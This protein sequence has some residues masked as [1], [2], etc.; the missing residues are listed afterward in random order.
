MSSSVERITAQSK[1]EAVHGRAAALVQRQRQ[2]NDR[3]D[4]FFREIAEVRT[5]LRDEGSLWEGP[6]MDPPIEAAFNAWSSSGPKETRV[7][8]ERIREAPLMRLEEPKTIVLR[9]PDE[10]GFGD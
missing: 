4:A 2:L 7:Q 9:S 3:L 10:V 8:L 1:T 6:V 5:L